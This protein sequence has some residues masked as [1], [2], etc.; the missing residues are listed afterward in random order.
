M[1][2][3]LKLFKINFYNTY[4]KEGVCH[5]FSLIPAEE[6]QQWMERYRMKLVA[7]PGYFEVCWLTANLTAPLQCLQTK[8]AEK[9]LTF[10]L[11]LKNPY[12]VNFSA[13]NINQEEA[14]TYY[15]HNL[16]DPASLQGEEYVS[17]ADKIPINKVNNYPTKPGKA[18]FGI[19]D[20]YLEQWWK[21]HKGVEEKLPVN[22]NIRFKARETTWR[23]CVIDTK[24]RFKNFMKI[25]GGQKDNHF[26]TRT[27][28]NGR[29]EKMHV[30]ESTKPLP[31]VDKPDHFFSLEIDKAEDRS[32]QKKL[33]IETLPPP[34]VDSLKREVQGK[35]F[36]SEIFIYV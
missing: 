22:Y 18:I 17:D 4:Y 30:F 34:A 35:N 25:V 31:W 28:T 29:G 9:K 19:V 6:S 5:D 20:I 14:K 33:L 10:F 1:A 12:L 16:R 3:S 11:I 32:S 23:Y 24:Q 8:I 13:L 15:F 7:Q 21:A 36:Y 26:T 27:M 2:F